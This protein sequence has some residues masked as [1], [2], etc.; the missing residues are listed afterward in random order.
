MWQEVVAHHGMWWHRENI[1]AH[2][3][4]GGSSGNVVA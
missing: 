3:E 4:C 2:R 1:V